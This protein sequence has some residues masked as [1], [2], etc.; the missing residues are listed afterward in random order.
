MLF[1]VMLGLPRP[2]WTV[3]YV[4]KQGIW[5]ISE[6]P[7]IILLY[8]LTAVTKSTQL[9]KTRLFSEYDLNISSWNQACAWKTSFISGSLK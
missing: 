1:L 6:F 8:L 4:R 5:E 2:K 9:I 7:S 3:E